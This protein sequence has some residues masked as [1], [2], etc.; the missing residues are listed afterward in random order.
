MLD[1]SF[2]Y[3]NFKIIHEV[4]NRKGNYSH[5]FYNEEYQNICDKVS[6]KR[7]ELKD[8]IKAG[9]TK[10][11]LALIESEKKDLERSKEDLLENDLLKFS[12]KV[13][14][15]NF[16]MKV[17]SFKNTKDG[18]TIYSVAKIPETY[19]AMKQLQ[20]N[21]SKTFKVKQAS[22]HQIVKQIK[23]LFEDGFP[24]FII[25]ADIH[26]FYESVPQSQLLDLI[27]QNSILSPRSKNLIYNLMY[28]YNKES[29]QL[30]YPPS[31][32]IGIPRGVGVSAYLAEVYMKKVDEEITDLPGVTYFARYVD[33][34]IVIFTPNTKYDTSDYMLQVEK[35]VSK[36]GL[37]LKKGN[38]TKTVNCLL[39]GENRTFSYLGYTFK[40]TNAG[41][42][43]ITLSDGK[44]SRYIEKMQLSLQS[45]LHE[46]KYN[47]KLARSLLIH[48]FNY[49]TKNTE[50]H[51]PKKGMIG[52]YYSNS[53]INGNC[54]CLKTLDAELLK[55]VDKL[56]PIIDFPRL[57]PRLKK[58][59]F[60]D[61]YC[62]KNF[63]NV[64]SAHK[65][66]PHFKM[67]Y[68]KIERVS[69]SNFEKIIKA[70]KQ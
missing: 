48:R 8:A 11:I 37:K 4:E 12:E 28:N 53:L 15:A 62:K 70:W 33:D 29:N 51:Q 2:S 46:K 26:Q 41:F 55:L 35:I 32:R 22:R 23:V 1:Q 47:E 10:E 13:N 20:H 64:T 45:Y 43:G 59:S 56:L 7:K 34:L 50:L 39:G 69:R 68:E 30:L 6:I 58:F 52:I 21:V 5:D 25:R 36:Y 54:C 17:R 60:V 31:A 3:N 65:N 19:F 24:K 42:A 63:F 27:E 14:S 18:K 40:F 38:K 61:G 66:V 16:S 49:L 57:N 9:E 67:P 44:K